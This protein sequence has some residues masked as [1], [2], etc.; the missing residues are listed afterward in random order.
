MAQIFG[1]EIGTGTFVTRVNLNT[2]RTAVRAVAPGVTQILY[3][4]DDA[5][6]TDPAE[7]FR[8]TIE[9][10]H[11]NQA[12]WLPM[13][14]SE[15]VGGTKDR[16]GNPPS[17]MVTVSPAVTHLRITLTPLTGT[18]RVGIIGDVI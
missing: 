16:A 4:L 2:T 14:V 1:K 8:M 10:S 3:Q 18:P 6:F 12:S 9:Q 7:S 13:S 11:D 15:F 17:G 5:Q